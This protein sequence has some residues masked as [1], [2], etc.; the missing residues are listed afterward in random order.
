MNTSVIAFAKAHGFDDAAYMK[1]WNGKKIYEPIS[2]SP[3][4]VGLLDLI[5]EDTP[6][7]FCTTEEAQLILFGKIIFTDWKPEYE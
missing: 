7:R 4:S 3:F 6:V 2:K 1:T 5:I